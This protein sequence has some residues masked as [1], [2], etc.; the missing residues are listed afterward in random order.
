MN[1]DQQPGVPC[2]VPHP[3]GL[4]APC[5]RFIPPGWDVEDGHPGGH[6]WASDAAQEALD[7][8]HY[9]AAAALS[10]QPFTTH[11]PEDCTPDC[12]QWT[13]RRCLVL[14][15]NYR[16]PVP[17]VNLACGQS[18]V[19]FDRNR[20]TFLATLAA[21]PACLAVQAA[22]VVVIEAGG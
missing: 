2:P 21:C 3:D 13:G 16:S 9:D 8:H 19:P 1:P 5:R 22:R 4:D 20:H 17:L 11:K 14:E 18:G 7:N 10:G 6:W 12:L 15:S